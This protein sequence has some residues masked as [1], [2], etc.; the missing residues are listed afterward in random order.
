MDYQLLKNNLLINVQ[1]IHQLIQGV[2]FEQARWRPDPSS[3][4]IVEVINHL[5]DEER[6]DFRV[7]LD[8]ILHFP[9]N[10]WPP[11]DP[12]GWVIEGNYQ[13][14]DLDDSF[15][16]FLTERRNSLNWVEKLESPNWD[17]VYTTSFGTMKA[18][19]ILCAWVAHDLLHMRQLIEL[20]YA[21]LATTTKPFSMEYA[22]EW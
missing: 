2:A 19:D 21:Y 8:I 17:A 6:L 15:A 18:G 20:H 9:D 7:R 10:P 1:R 14:R 3:W 22:G 16:K 5:L 12:K 4:S 11:I 13:Q